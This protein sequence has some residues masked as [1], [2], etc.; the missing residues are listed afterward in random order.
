MSVVGARRTTFALFGATGRAGR[1]LTAAA[2]RRGYDVRAL[3]RDAARQAT[4][5]G[6][7]VVV[8]D[9]LDPAAVA[10]TLDGC[11]AVLSSLGGGTT[12]EPGVTRSLGMQHVVAAMQAAGLRRIVALGGGGVLDATSAPGLRADQPTYPAVFRLVTAE[13][14]AAWDLLR[15]SGLDWTYVCPPD[16]P[17]GDATGV[18]RTA[19]DIM[20]ERPKPLPTG[21]LAEFMV[22]EVEGRRFLHRRVGIC[23]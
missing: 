7:T 23:T 20:P 2:L 22:D 15:E 5:D 16:I 10:T 13:H 3:V 4:V 21:D 9:V 17:D 14:R 12:A 18:Y 11:H 19:A 6:V 8:G 1:R